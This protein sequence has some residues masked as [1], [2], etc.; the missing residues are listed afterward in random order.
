MIM[1]FQKFTP[2][3]SDDSVYDSLSGECYFENQFD[4]TSTNTVLN[5]EFTCSEDAQ[6]DLTRRTCV[7]SSCSISCSR[8]GNITTFK[9]TLI[10]I[11]ASVSSSQYLEVD[12]S[13]QN[14]WLNVGDYVGCTNVAYL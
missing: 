14:I 7:S 6:F 8:E 12:V 2:T 10:D 11:E 13:A 4:G 3:C 1:S 9:E 5:Q